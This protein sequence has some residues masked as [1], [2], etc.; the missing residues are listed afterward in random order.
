MISTKWVVSA[1][2]FP[3]TF[4][5]VGLNTITVNGTGAGREGIGVGVSRTV[6]VRAGVGQTDVEG[7]D[8]GVDPTTGDEAGARVGQIVGVGVCKNV[9]VFKNVRVGTGL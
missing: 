3:H 6:G 5:F 8:A 2:T 4:D 7:A 9:W 1:W